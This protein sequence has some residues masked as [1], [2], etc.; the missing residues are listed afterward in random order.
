MGYGVAIWSAEIASPLLT[1]VV[2]I[3]NIYVGL[4]ILPNIFEIIWEII[5]TRFFSD[6]VASVLV[7]YLIFC[8]S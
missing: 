3:Q 5:A 4:D 1:F 7:D 8:I 2:S 6:K